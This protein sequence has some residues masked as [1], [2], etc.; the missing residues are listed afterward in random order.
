MSYGT[1]ILR[2]LLNYFLV[3]DYTISS[4]VKKLNDWISYSR[5]RYMYH[6]N[7]Y[8]WDIFW[9]TLM[10]IVTYE[11]MYLYVWYGI[12]DTEDMNCMYVTIWKAG[13][14]YC[15][16]SLYASYKM[17]TYRKGTNS[18]WTVFPECLFNSSVKFVDWHC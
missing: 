13:N 18:I 9:N 5:H 4:K 17:S 15:A 6:S 7:L 12:T 10:N 8:Y 11:R 1:K 3:L 16:L 2:S 14:R